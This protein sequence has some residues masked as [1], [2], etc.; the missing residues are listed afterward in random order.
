M[1]V[2]PESGPES[3]E[4]RFHELLFRFLSNISSG[5]LVSYGDLIE[6]I[7]HLREEI[8][9]AHFPEEKAEGLPP[10][11]LF[12]AKSLPQPR[13]WRGGVGM[14]VWWADPSTIRL[15]VSFLAPQD[16]GVFKF[17]YLLL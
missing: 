14:C 2:F 13:Q 4:C 15:T 9:T 5:A 10:V 12:S 16:T 17:L 3:P 8:H 1:S 11:L 6:D 7:I